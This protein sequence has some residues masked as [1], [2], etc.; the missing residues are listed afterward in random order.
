MC[1]WAPMDAALHR[2]TPLGQGPIMIMSCVLTRKQTGTY[3]IHACQHIFGPQRVSR[4]GIQ[5]FK[6]DPDDTQSD[7]LR[8]HLQHSC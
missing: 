2:N 8:L 3:M 1:T 6:Q 4:L 5:L 7:L